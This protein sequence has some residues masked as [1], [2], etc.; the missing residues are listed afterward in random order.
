[1]QKYRQLAANTSVTGNDI[2]KINMIVVQIVVV[3]NNIK[4]VHYSFIGNTGKYSDNTYSFL[5]DN[6]YL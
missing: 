5:I 1:M 3:H 2:W 4:H 6:R